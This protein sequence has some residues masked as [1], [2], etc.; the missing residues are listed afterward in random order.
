[1]SLTK[2][3]EIDQFPLT[4]NII[5]SIYAGVAEFRHTRMSQTHVFEG[6]SPSP[7]TN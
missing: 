5:V 7:G 2:P 4:P 1:M 6:S 3:N